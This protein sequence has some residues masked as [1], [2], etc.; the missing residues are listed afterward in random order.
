MCKIDVLENNL[1]RIFHLEWQLL[2][3]TTSSS[4]VTD[5]AESRR[6]ETV[7]D[8]SVKW[9]SWQVR[10]RFVVSAMQLFFEF[11]WQQKGCLL[12][13]LIGKCVFWEFLEKL[14]I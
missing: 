7:K 4:N 5:T 6:P 12:N 3:Q 11:P 1:K 9:S 2:I 10:D 13:T 14:C 8:S